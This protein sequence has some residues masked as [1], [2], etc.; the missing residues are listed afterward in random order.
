ML[1]AYQLYQL[2][3]VGPIGNSDK[4]STA[5]TNNPINSLFEDVIVVLNDDNKT[6]M[7]R[8]KKCDYVTGNQFHSK[9]S[10]SYV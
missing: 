5:S 1:L 8:C 10:H 3:N 9:R 6:L 7:K 4:M 2:L